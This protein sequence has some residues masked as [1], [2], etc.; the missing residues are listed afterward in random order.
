[1]KNGRCLAILERRRAL[2]LAYLM[3]ASRYS[4]SVTVKEELRRKRSKRTFCGVDTLDLGSTHCEGAN[5][6]ACAAHTLQ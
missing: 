3:R 2:L 5:G 6:E 1:M 4:H